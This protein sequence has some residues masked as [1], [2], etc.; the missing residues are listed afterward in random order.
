[1][2]TVLLVTTTIILLS[3]RPIC[4]NIT[5]NIMGFI[6]PNIKL[7]C[8]ST[9]FQAVMNSRPIILHIGYIGLL[10]CVMAAPVFSEFIIM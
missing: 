9:S 5:G 1:M 10:M 4:Q 2:N 7:V 8:T 6:M 3:S